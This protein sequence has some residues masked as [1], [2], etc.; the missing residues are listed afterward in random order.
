MNLYN[1]ELWSNLTFKTVCYRKNF[2]MITKNEHIFTEYD[3]N[4]TMLRLKENSKPL[5]IGE[6]GFT[7][8]NIGL[9][10]LLN[11]DYIE[12][13][14]EYSADSITY[15]KLMNCISD[16]EFNINNYK[17]IILIHSLVITSKY[18]KR[19]VTEEFVEAMYRDFYDKDT[20]IIALV[21]PVQ[22]N[23]SDDDYYTNHK[24]IPVIKKI[25]GVETTEKVMASEYYSLPDLYEKKDSE[26]NELK[27]FSIASKCG[28]NRIGESNLFQFTPEITIERLKGKTIKLK[29]YENNQ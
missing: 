10:K 17:K 26:Y 2:D 4:V 3:G 29:K 16:K 28:F 19:G 24:S 8:I 6:Y 12:L 7:M 21:L 14:K 11:I 23:A 9:A 18:R 5:T 22:N 13:I 20:A 15:E 25:G 27:L 1:L